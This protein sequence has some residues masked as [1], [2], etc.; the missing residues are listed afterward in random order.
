[1]TLT[2]PALRYLEGFGVVAPVAGVGVL[3]GV[4]RGADESRPV[5]V[6]LLALIVPFR[7]RKWPF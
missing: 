4:V 7:Q 6:F 3:L 2:T 5:Q 1:M